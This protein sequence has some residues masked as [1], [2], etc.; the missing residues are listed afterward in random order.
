MKYLKTYKTFESLEESLKSRLIG[1]Y[2]DRESDY[3]EEE[4]ANVIE[5]L[6]EYDDNLTGLGGWDKTLLLRLVDDEELY[7]EVD[8]ISTGNSISGNVF[9]NFTIDKSEENPEKAN[10]K[11][12]SLIFNTRYIFAVESALRK[13]G[14][15]FEE[16]NRN[17][18]YHLKKNNR[19]EYFAWSNSSNELSK[20][21]AINDLQISR[22]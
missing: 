8:S 12:Y 11:K 19:C 22:A 1:Y 6:N 4:I 17:Q 18:F 15:K 5:I 14:V 7:Q 2:H 3:D 9:D 10:L 21:L 13:A 16:S 20:L